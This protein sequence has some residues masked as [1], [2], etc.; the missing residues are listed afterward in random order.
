MLER[1]V[2]GGYQI[3]SPEI[4][5]DSPIAAQGGV[6]A[7]TYERPR[8]RSLPK[9]NRS[10]DAVSTRPPPPPPPP[11]PA[12]QLALIGSGF[13]RQPWN[14]RA[15]T[16]LNEDPAFRAACEICNT[17]RP[18]AAADTVS[19]GTGGGGG[20]QRHDDWD[21]NEVLKSCGGGGGGGGGGGSR[22]GGGIPA[23]ASALM[24]SFSPAVTPAVAAG[25]GPTA[26]ASSVAAGAGAVAPPP[27]IEACIPSGFSVGDG[28]T[29]GLPV[30][31]IEVGDNEVDGILGGVSPGGGAF[32]VVSGNDQ[33]ESGHCGRA[34]A[35]SAA[36][37]GGSW[38]A[39]D[40]WQGFGSGSFRQESPVNCSP[41]QPAKAFEFSF[42]NSEAGDGGGGG[43]GEGAG[44]GNDGRRVDN[45]KFGR[46][47]CAP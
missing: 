39:G 38:E 21:D 35:G 9:W 17:P 19:S 5:R 2:D 31:G 24:S 6:V 20:E 43:V 28:E 36:A 30:G 23:T 34:T 11:R 45:V 1:R 13:S 26:F 25:G 4:E 3:F 12:S 37:L 32:P 44:D 8:G 33:A 29:G 18:S 7:R 47:G 27:Q 40:E 14:C 16:Y 46:E 15:C 10:D 22:G 42:G 41:R